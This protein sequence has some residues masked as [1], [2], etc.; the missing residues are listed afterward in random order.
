MKTKHETWK[1]QKH[2]LERWME[3]N[4]HHVHRDGKVLCV[5][6][7]TDI[8][9]KIFAKFKRR[10]MKRVHHVMYTYKGHPYVMSHR[11]FTCALSQSDRSSCA[12]YVIALAFDVSYQEAFDLLADKCNRKKGEGTR[13]YL[14][15]KML[16][17]LTLNGKRSEPILD[18]KGNKDNPM[19]YKMRNGQEM[20]RRLTVNRFIEQYP[21]NGTY[22]VS[23]RKHVFV[24]KDGITYGNS[25][26]A[27]KK[28]KRIDRVWKIVNN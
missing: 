27:N 12:V 7:F 14:M 3:G 8:A 21:K 11:E 22:I 13:T 9:D 4:M 15:D 6:K 25:D 28:G 26:D 5:T 2:T 19:F 17:E 20:A 18:A 1:N 16:D 23:V 24:I 10:D